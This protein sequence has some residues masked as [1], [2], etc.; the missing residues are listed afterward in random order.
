MRR[1]SATP[2]PLDVAGVK[3][4][5]VKVR[6]DAATAAAAAA[7]A[8]VVV[9][10]LFRFTCPLNSGPLLLSMAVA[11]IDK[12]LPLAVAIPFRLLDAAVAA[13]AAAAADLR[14]ETI[15]A[16]RMDSGLE[17]GVRS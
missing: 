10:V 6:T 7:A 8:V 2:P 16:A 13:T 14:A 12:T 4:K 5:A 17:G 15:E 3:P 9:V 1:R 11:A